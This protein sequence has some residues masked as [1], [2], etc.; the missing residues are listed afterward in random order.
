VRIEDL[1]PERAPE[2]ADMLARAF[3]DEPYV[4]HMHGPDRATRLA[5]LQ[6]HYARLDLGATDVVLT[7]A[8]L[9]SERIV[10]ATLAA[11]PGRC[12]ACAGPPPAAGPGERDYREGLALVHRAQPPHAWLAKLAVHPDHQ[13]R[14]VGTALVHEFES[15]L[16]SL[17]VE[18]VLVE[19]QPHRAAFYAALGYATVTRFPDPGGPDAHL[20]ARALTP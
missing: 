4:V 16:A 19:C 7:A 17:G 14:G 13:G 8:D 5:R 20:M 9:D 12:P 10:G 11:T 6:E 18:R 2:L 1:D 3:V 15:R